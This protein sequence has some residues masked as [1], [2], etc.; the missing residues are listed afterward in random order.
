[1]KGGWRLRRKST[2]IKEEEVDDTS[3]LQHQ[4]PHKDTVTVQTMSP[5]LSYQSL[6]HTTR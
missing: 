2:A 1:M 5:K 4:Y 6:L 3:I